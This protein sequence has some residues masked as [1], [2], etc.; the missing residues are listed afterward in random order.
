[1]LISSI[2]IEIKVLLIYQILDYFV[3][4]PVGCGG[5]DWNDL[6]QGRNQWRTLVNIVMNLRVP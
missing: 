2:V 5:T 3:R 6:G 4:H 1:M